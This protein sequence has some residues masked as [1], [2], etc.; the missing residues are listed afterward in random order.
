MK[1]VLAVVAA[2]VLANVSMSNGQCNDPYDANLCVY[3]LTD[4]EANQFSRN[5]QVS[6]FWNSWAGRD[7]AEMVPPGSCYPGRCNF[8]GAEDATLTIKAAG[9]NKGLYILTTV[10]D[11]TWVDRANAEDWGADAI[12]FYFDGRSADD[13]FT[14]TYCL[15]GLYGS[16][17]SYSTQQFQVWMGASALPTG[18]RYA[19]YDEQ[20]WSWQTMGV[21][22]D[23]AVVLYGYQIDIIS[24][25]ATQKAQEWFFPWTTYDQ[26][27][28]RLQVGAALAGMKVA[29]SGG[30]NDKDGDNAEPDC[31]RWLQGDP[32]SEDAKTVNKWGNFELTGT[33][34]GNV[35]AWGSG[36]VQQPARRALGTAAAVNGAN[37]YYNLRGQKINA[38]AVQNLRSNAVVVQNG[39]ARSNVQV[40]GR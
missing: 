3:H 23:N 33:T 8:S 21:T 29:F 12:D 11:N 37:Q 4:D 10:T 28:G 31:L 6:E 14:C 13:I 25:S 20:L 35:E 22:F 34:W 17:L 16:T 1:R 2:C 40:I 30:Y 32:W 7:Y 36:N 27:S 15:I 24:I 26:G 18:C 5:G 38:P 9:T 39:A 19:Y